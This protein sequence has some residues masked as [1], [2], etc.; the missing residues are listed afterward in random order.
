MDKYNG[1]GAI[2]GVVAKAVTLKSNTTPE[3]E[4]ILK[5]A[6]IMAKV[7]AANAAKQM[8]ADLD[9]VLAAIA[10]ELNNSAKKI[11]MEEE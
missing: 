7:A 6:V 5:A 4:D 8:D 10:G 11:F 2:I 3:Q 1:F 9:V